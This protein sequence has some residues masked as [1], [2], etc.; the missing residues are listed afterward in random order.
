M[1]LTIGGILEMDLAVR[2]LADAERESILRAVLGAYDSGVLITDLHHRSLACNRQFGEIFGVVPADVVRFGVEELRRK[3]LPIIVDREAWLASLKEVYADPTCT[4]LDELVLNRGKRVVLRRYSAP[5]LNARGDVMGRIWTFR[6]ISAERRLDEMREVLQHISTIQ[7]PD[8]NLVCNRIL[9]AVSLYYDNTTA[10]LSIRRDD[11]LDFKGIVGPKSGLMRITGNAVRDSYCQFALRSLRPLII[12]DARRQPECARVR[13]ARAGYTRYLGVPIL[14]ESSEPIGTLCLLDSKS[15]APL[16]EHDIQ[17]MSLMGMRIAAELAR[18]RH[19]RERLA[20]KDEQL[21]RQRKDLTV[22]HGVFDA[23]NSA[24]ALLG[25]CPETSDLLREQTLLL[26]GV[27]GYEGAAVMIRRTTETHF[28]GFAVAIGSKKATPA[29]LDAPEVGEAFLRNSNAKLIQKLNAATVSTALRTEDGVGDIL[30]AFG[31]TNE[32]PEDE[33]HRIHLDALADQVCLLLATQVLQ[34]E[35]LQTNCELTEAHVEI[36]RKEKLSVV[37]TL[38]A[39]TAHDIRNITASLALLVAPGNDPEHSLQ[40]VREQLARFNVLAHRL[41]SYARPRMV[42][43]RKM[44]IAPLVD[45]VLALTAAQMRVSRVVVDTRIPANLPM[46]VGDPHQIEH[47]LVNLILN[48]A[49]AMDATGGKLRIEASEK[50]GH[51]RMRVV[52]TG[53]GIPKEALA[54]LF[55]PFASTRA[56]GFGLGLYS[57]KRIAEEHGGTITAQR[58]PIVGST[59]TILLPLGGAE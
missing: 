8:P 45:G 3:V 21:L 32:P 29:S 44:E 15:A 23:M 12:Q 36:L 46:I 30:I 56:N 55:E 1:S 27:L 38:A 4:R 24:F 34:S 39:S 59:F 19:I 48:S 13:P 43:K 35:L 50:S 5:V 22:T 40:A 2:G 6:D 37:G 52:D 28:H 11:M 57:C 53:P 17:F 14:D 54:R 10:I 18:E 20:E 58:N 49:Q 25:E 51:V 7:D 33:R 41:L 31:R 16:D 42:A 9:E 47:L 26:N